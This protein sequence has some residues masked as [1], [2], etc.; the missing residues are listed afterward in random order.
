MTA[1]LLFAASFALVFTL[2]LQQM[3]VE[4]GDKA[5]AFFT[6]PLIGL[7][8]LALFKFLPGPTDA[9]EIG[10]YLSGGAFGIVASM[11]MHPHL[12]ALLKLATEYNSLSLSPFSPGMGPM[13]YVGEAPTIYAGY[14]LREGETLTTDEHAAKLGET[15]RLATE[16]ADDVSRSDIESFCVRTELDDVDWFDTHRPDVDFESGCVAK[17]LRYLDL[18]NRVIH[19]PQQPHLVRFE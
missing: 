2:G 1:A 4:R 5:A 9:V 19:H 12:V 8:N 16:L 14:P 3:N 17:A 6:S 10:A 13:P 7:A 15:L 11:W 18:R